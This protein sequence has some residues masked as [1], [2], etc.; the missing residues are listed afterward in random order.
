M[1]YQGICSERGKTV[2]ESEAFEYALNKTK[3]SEDWQEEFVR[4]YGE[5]FDESI[6]IGEEDDFVDWFFSGNWI[7]VKDEES[8]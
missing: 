7:K 3:N 6:I 2:D 1:Y 8:D 5:E 4:C